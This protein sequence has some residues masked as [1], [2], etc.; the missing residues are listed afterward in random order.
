MTDKIFDNTNRGV[1]FRSKDQKTDK[2]PAYSGTINIDGKEFWLAGWV[3]ETKQ[4][5]KFFSLAVTPKEKK[6]E[7]AAT[8]TA[9]DDLD[10]P[11]F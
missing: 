5:E 1:L 8:P 11:P 2:H 3:K 7:R 10:S 6:V 9:F 4:N